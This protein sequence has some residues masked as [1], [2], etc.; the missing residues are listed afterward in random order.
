MQ[1]AGDAIGD[2]V[3]KKSSAEPWL[4]ESGVLAQAAE[5]VSLLKSR[6][7][8]YLCCVNVLIAGKAAIAGSDLIQT[9]DFGLRLRAS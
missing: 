8:S 7:D 3:L 1:R 2:E 5:V 6:T 9:E 4:T